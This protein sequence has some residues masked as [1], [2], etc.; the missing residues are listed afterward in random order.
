MTPKKEEVRMNE[1]N[2]CIACT[3]TQC[4]YHCNSENY[5]SL[6]KIQVGSH[7]ADPTMKQCTDCMS[8]A[9]K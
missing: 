1:A 5:C 7:E 9:K 2:R 3:V 4:K 8:F 6:E